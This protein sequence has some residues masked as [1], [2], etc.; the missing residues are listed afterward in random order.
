MK[1]IIK[2]VIVIII[3]IVCSLFLDTLFACVFDHSPL[4][5]LK[6]KQSDS[7][8]W[9]DKGLFVDTYYCTK[10]S[11]IITVYQHFKG[12]KFEC[13][14]DN[15]NTFEIKEIVDKTLEQDN[16][17]CAQ[18]LEKFYEDDDNEYYFSCIKGSYIVVIYT[19]DKEQP[20]SEALKEGK[21]TISDLDR[22]NI[23]YYKENKVK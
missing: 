8:S 3:A 21:I 19:N 12:T 7:D 16:F 22:F 5:H 18:A 1:K 4:I 10:E 20:V 6:D 13:P 9:V 14:I 23:K 11:D 15:E 17:T 2:I